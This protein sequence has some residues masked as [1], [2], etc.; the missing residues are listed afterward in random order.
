M[1]QLKDLCQKASSNI[2]QK[3]LEGHEG[4]Y[5][6]YGASGLIGYVDFYKQENPYV[7]VVKDGA[8]IGRVM[9]LPEKSSVIGTMQYILPNEGVNVH[10]LA[11]AMEHMNLAKYFSGATIPH[12]Y[13]KDYG[14]EKLLERTEKEQKSIAEILNKMD[15]LISLRKQQIAKL[16]ELVKARFVEMFGNIIRNDKSWPIHNFSDIASSRLGKMLDAKQQTGKYSYPYLANFNVQWFNF[17]VDNLNQMDFNEAEQK[18]FELRD[19]DLLVCEGGEIGRCA[20]WHNEIQP[21][22]FQ[23]ALHRVRCN[24]QLV[25]PDYLAWWFKYNC[26]H[27]GFAEI[28]GA[29]AT[30]AHLPGIKLKQLQVAL[31]PLSLQNEFAA[32][33]ERIDQQKQTVQQSLEKLELMKKALMQEYFG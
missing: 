29:K 23:K 27:G 32:F 3:D 14:K 28:A 16:D 33:V 17:N 25:Q 2:A 31:P 11:F 4:Q 30:I 6:I 20:V 15:S 1:I 5:P 9:C 26:N 13:F 8:G 12:I 19:G 21:C 24:R 18:E 7:A 22:F 10:Y